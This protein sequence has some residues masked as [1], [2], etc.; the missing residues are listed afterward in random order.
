MVDKFGEVSVLRP[1][2]CKP[3][4][5]AVFN[6]ESACASRTGLSAELTTI[7]DLSFERFHHA[8]VKHFVDP[9]NRM[10]RQMR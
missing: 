8:S 3:W 1:Y 5:K 6:L 4:A 2:F 10:V 7:N 9:E